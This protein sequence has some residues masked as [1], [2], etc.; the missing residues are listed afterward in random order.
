[1]CRGN[2]KTPVNHHGAAFCGKR[3]A[4]RWCSARCCRQRPTSCRSPASLRCLNH[5]QKPHRITIT[6]PTRRATT[7]QTY[8]Y[9]QIY[10]SFHGGAGARAEPVRSNCSRLVVKGDRLNN[11]NRRLTRRQPTFES[12]RPIPTTTKNTKK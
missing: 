4:S 8:I 5:H 2:T 9:C 7:C 10:P 1:M 11:N 3:K 12:R 6:P